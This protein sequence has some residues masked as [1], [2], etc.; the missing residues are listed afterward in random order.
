MGTDD[1]KKD[2]RRLKRKEK[3]VVNAYIVEDPC[4]DARDDEDKATGKVK[5]YD[6]PGKV[7]DK[8]R[9]AINDSDEG[10]GM[11]AFDP[12]EN[13]HTFLLKVGSTKPQAD[14]KSWP[15]YGLS[16]FSMKPGPIAEDEKALDAIMETRH[17]L[18]SHMKGELRSESN[19]VKALRD[20]GFYEYI[21]DK[22]DATESAK[23]ADTTAAPVE[24]SKPEPRSVKQEVAD[25]EEELKREEVSSDGD[26]N[27]QEDLLAQ[28]D[29]I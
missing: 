23:P 8:I 11:A 6:F 16:K 22:V 25:P 12:T 5:I 21:K 17:D 19:I 10:V 9:D 27:I 2:A 14:N 29:K 24:E 20:E 15:D 28:L 3:Y 13:G 26:S 1:D 18:D 7:E 4:D